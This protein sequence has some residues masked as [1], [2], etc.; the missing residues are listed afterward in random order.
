LAAAAL[1]QYG[2][3]GDIGDGVAFG[4]FAGGLLPPNVA[5]PAQFGAQA[6]L[7]NKGSSNYHALLLTLSKNLSQGLQF[8]FNYTLSHSIDN[9]SQ[10]SG[11]NAL[12]E[13]TGIIC[14]A[15]QP[16]ACRGDSDFD[17]RQIITADFE[18]DLPFGHNKRYLGDS[19]TLTNELIGGWSVSGIPSFRTGLPINVLSDAFLA[20]FAA[21]DPAIYTGIHSQLASLKSHPN[22]VQG[23]VYNFAGGPTGAATAYSLFRGPIGLE[24]GS[25]NLL[26]GPNA[27]N[28]DLGLAKIFPIIPSRQ[29]NLIFRADAFN[30]FN[31]P[32]F[33]NPG[34][35]EPD[36][37]DNASPFGQITSTISPPGQVGDIRVAQFSLR[38]EF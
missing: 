30:L 19:G 14:D 9:N 20:S 21:E 24:Y 36:I 22:N 10:S 18:Y 37:V 38:L 15:T 8:S 5:M 4:L 2:L 16:R 25:R 27:A 23:T 29:I 28:L 31:H 12:Y 33:S 1:G 32:N 26:K 13:V 7:T 17:V 11:T 3:R 6:Y 34:A 35:S